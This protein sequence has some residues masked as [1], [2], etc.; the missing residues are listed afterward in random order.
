MFSKGSFRDTYKE[1]FKCLGNLA[2][3]AQD[4][5]KLSLVKMSLKQLRERNS[6]FAS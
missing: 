3:K 5:N 6:S 2:S 4:E 1:S